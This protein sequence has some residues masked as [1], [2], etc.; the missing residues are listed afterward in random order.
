MRQSSYAYAVAAAVVLMRAIPATSAEG[1][2]LSG[3]RQSHQNQASL[4][5]TNGLGERHAMEVM[6]G[7]CMGLT[8]GLYGDADN[9]IV[10]KA[11]GIEKADHDSPQAGKK[12]VVLRPRS[13]MSCTLA[14]STPQPAAQGIVET[15]PTP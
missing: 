13:M 5:A 15:A 6:L 3:E 2:A 11:D 8:P 1:P 12:G 14:P 4:M 9:P 7:K 10:V